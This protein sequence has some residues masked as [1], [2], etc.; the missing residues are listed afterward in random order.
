MVGAGHLAE[1][2]AAVDGHREVADFLVAVE[3]LV[4]EAAAVRGRLSSIDK[5]RIPP[6]NLIVISVE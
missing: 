6:F 3:V 4:A 2:G 1:D 5:V